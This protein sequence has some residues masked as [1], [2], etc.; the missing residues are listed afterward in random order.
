MHKIAKIVVTGNKILNADFLIAAS[1]HKVGDA[2]DS[3]TL[4]E[5]KSAIFATGLFGFGS[6]DS[7]VRVSS[8]E[9]TSDGTCVVSIDVDENPKIERVEITGET[10]DHRQSAGRITLRH[11]PIET[12]PD[13]DRR[14]V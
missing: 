5:M 9:N 7:S 14:R 2:C 1:R 11:G 4:L 13:R 8:Q 12:R 10:A 6:D 3:Q